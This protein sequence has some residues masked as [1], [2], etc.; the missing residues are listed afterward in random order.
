MNAPSILVRCPKLLRES[1]LANLKETA[2][3]RTIV[4]GCPI[5]IGV[6]HLRR[7][8]SQSARAINTPG[9]SAVCQLHPVS[10]LDSL[11]RA[12]SPGLNCDELRNR[13][14]TPPK[15]LVGCARSGNHLE[16][17]SAKHVQV[18]SGN[19]GIYPI[20]ISAA[21]LPYRDAHRPV[22]LDISGDELSIRPL[23]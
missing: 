15:R 4:S 14:T 9:N 7:C 1:A 6:P 5:R 8:F 2:N 22:V 16:R 3:R 20:L 13:E 21:L 18:P 23:P 12:S 11:V 10:N 19:L 17:R